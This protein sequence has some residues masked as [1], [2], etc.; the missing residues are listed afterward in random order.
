MQRWYEIRSYINKLWKYFDQQMAFFS[1][2]V[3]LAMK[4]NY[5]LCRGSLFFFYADTIEMRSYGE[6]VQ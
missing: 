2:K 1:V 6:N 5:K 4:N 3:L